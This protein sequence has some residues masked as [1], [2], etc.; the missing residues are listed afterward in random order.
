MNPIRLFRRIRAFVIRDFQLALSYR[1]EFFMR[2]VTVLLIV[3]AFYF[4]SLIF[5]SSA[6]TEFAQW[7]NPLAAWITGLAMINYFMTGF[8]SLANAIR[9]EQAQ[10]TL[11]SVL[12][13]P[14]SI[15]ALIVSSSAWDFVQATFFSFLYFFFGWI[16]FGITF[17]GS[18]TLAILFLL[19]TTLVLA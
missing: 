19:L 6:S 12:V 1:L 17:E 4:I 18:Y 16:F 15:P 9:A 3:T 14:I 10:G 2:I 11:E 8:S 13:T 5:E 7:R